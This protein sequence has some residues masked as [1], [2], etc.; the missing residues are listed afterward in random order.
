M[1][2]Y[3]VE[4]NGEDVELSLEDISGIDM[5]TVEEFEGGFE[6]T[7]V[8]S[9]AFL[10][11][12]AQITEIADKPTIQFEL[13]VIGCDAINSETKDEQSIVGWIHKETIFV[14]DIAKS[15]GQ[16]KAIMGHAGFTK[17]GALKELLDEFCGWKF[18][19][20]T[21]QTKDR[22]DPDKIYANLK[23]KTI[24]PMQDATQA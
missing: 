17:V 16:A 1:T 5:S 18:T 19:A 13:E 9:Y 3:T 21:K 14:N 15:V 6:A 7:P 10:V 24:E 2:E 8:G 4:L 23:I 12:D 20:L 22:N 11:K